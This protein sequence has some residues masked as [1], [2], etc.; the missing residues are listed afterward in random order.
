MFYILAPLHLEDDA[1]YSITLFQ[2]F[3]YISLLIC[4]NGDR[5]KKSLKKQ[6]YV[7]C[8]DCNLQFYVLKKN[9]CWLLHEQED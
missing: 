8:K 7:S 1:L 6:K 4:L 5:T 3:S 9:V 2:I